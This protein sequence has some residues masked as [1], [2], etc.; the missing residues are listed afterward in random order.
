MKLMSDYRR[1]II[2]T[3][4]RSVQDKPANQ[5]R[6]IRTAAGLG[7]LIMATCASAAPPFMVSRS[8]KVM[9]R[10]SKGIR[11]EHVL[12]LPMTA[13][14]RT[15]RLAPGVIWVGSHKVAAVDSQGLLCWHF[16]HG[17]VTRTLAAAGSLKTMPAGLF[18]SGR[19]AFAVTVA[20]SGKGKIPQI[21][22][23]GCTPRKNA[24]LFPVCSPQG[25]FGTANDLNSRWL[26]VIAPRTLKWMALFPSSACPQDRLRIWRFGRCAFSAQSVG[27]FETDNSAFS[28]DDGHFLGWVDGGHWVTLLAIGRASGQ[29]R[30]IHLVARLGLRYGALSARGKRM[31]LVAGHIGN[32][33]G[34]ELIMARTNAPARERVLTLWHAPYSAVGACPPVFS[35]SGALIAAATVRMGVHW[36]VGI[37]IISTKGFRTLYH[38]N[39]RNDLPVAFA[40]SR[41]GGNLA[42]ECWYHVLIFHIAGPRPNRVQTLFH[43][44]TWYASWSRPRTISLR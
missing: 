41:R 31:V 22:V 8:D 1:S 35:H 2:L 39:L 34:V 14:P 38:I 32:G 42:V 23:A 15:P 33:G 44:P 5:V 25:S 36:P 26:S 6:A 17:Q 7:A 20:R 29:P 9:T 11:L 30:R 21:S 24:G 37:W 10:F 18:G 19:R 43:R 12:A 13:G 28:S 3:G 4:F 27:L 16:A 40:F